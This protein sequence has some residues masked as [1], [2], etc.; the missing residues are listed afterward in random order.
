MGQWTAGERAG[1][2]LLALLA[3]G[4][5]VIAADIL[6]GGRFTRGCCGETAEDAGD[7]S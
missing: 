1:A 7:D 2:V 4:L 3:A 5:G 6:I